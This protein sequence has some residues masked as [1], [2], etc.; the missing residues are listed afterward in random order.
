MNAAE[1]KARFPGAYADYEKLAAA[2]AALLEKT[3]PLRRQYDALAKE[4]QALDA[5]VKALG[6][7]IIALERPALV[8]IDNQLSAL[9]LAMGGAR[10][11]QAA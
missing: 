9:D 1:K 11:S 6:A 10:L 8:D 3:K 7:Q 5:K 4:A 2:K